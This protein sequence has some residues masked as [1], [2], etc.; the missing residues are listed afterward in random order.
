MKA[1]VVSDTKC[2]EGYQE[3]IFAEIRSQAILKSDAYLDADSYIDMRAKRLK[4]LDNKQHLSHKEII[5][6]LIREEAWW[7]DIGNLHITEDN[8]DECIAKGLI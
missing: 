7:Y 2:P 6:I 8:L 1:W 3:Y 4:T 5:R